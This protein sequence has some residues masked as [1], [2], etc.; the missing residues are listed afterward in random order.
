M[1]LDIIR[2]TISEYNLLNKG[3]SVL[4][5]LSGGAD[6]VCL[7]YALNE[8]KEILGIEVYTAHVNHGIRGDEA[9]NDEL[10]A[11]K[12]SKSLGIKFFSARFNVPELAKQTGVSEETAG[13][14][15]RYEFFENL[16]NEYKISKI[17]TAHNKNDNAE[18]ILMNFMRGSTVKGLC[19]IPYKRGNVIRP[20]LDVSREMIEEY[21]QINKLEYVTDSTNLSNNYTRN[22]VRNILIP[23][24]K[25]NFNPNFVSTVTS[26][27]K[28]MIEDSYCLDQIAYGVY[29]KI[30]KHG[31]VSI[32]KLKENPVS[33]QRR[34]IRYMLSE[35]YSGLSDIPGI[36]ISD[37]LN[38]KHTGNGI[39][40]LNGVIAKIEY[41]KLKIGKFE[42]SKSLDFKYSLNV[43]CCAQIP[44]ILYSVSIEKCDKRKK[45]GYIYL[46]CDTDRIIIRNRQPGDRFYPSGMTGSKKLKQYFIDNK[47]PKEIR[48]S[49]PIIE[50][51]GEIAAVG[52]RVDNRFLFKDRGVK[53]KFDRR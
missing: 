28:L 50:I 15:A 32:S 11:E 42:S 44:E 8:L 34:V 30:A 48:S 1:I 18:T 5:G 6:S 3:D 24:V 26:N 25:E 35:V 38:L 10:F 46:G 53:I 36:Y 31:S 27:A 23:L 17:A 14:N 45:D 19:G 37:I 7:T 52:E 4:V 39:N 51:N 9:N 49:I 2:Q 47:I 29:S 13:R 33:I 41:D 16:C 21:C 12:F 22:K 43:P 20:I 40:L